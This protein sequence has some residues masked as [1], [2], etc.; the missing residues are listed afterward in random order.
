MFKQVEAKVGEAWIKAPQYEFFVNEM[1]KAGIKGN[2]P[3]RKLVL[4]FMG[5]LEVKETIAE[6][7]REAE[8][9]NVDDFKGRCRGAPARGMPPRVRVRSAPLSYGS[10]LD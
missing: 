10:G 3:A 2:T 7:K 8:G 6:A 9:E 4:D 5:S 1:I